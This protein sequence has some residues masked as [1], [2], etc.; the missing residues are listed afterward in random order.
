MLFVANFKLFLRPHYTNC[1]YLLVGLKN[2]YAKVNADI[3]KYSSIKLDYIES[4]IGIRTLFCVNLEI[5]IL[6]KRVDKK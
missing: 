6:K 3:T 1:I 2:K 5:L 4:V